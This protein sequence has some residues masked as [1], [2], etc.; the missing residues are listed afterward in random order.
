ARVTGADT[1]TDTDAR[2]VGAP[3]ADRVSAL[4]E[5]AR[6]LQE[7]GVAVEDIALR[8]PTLDEVFLHLTGNR[9]ADKT[10]T[11]VPA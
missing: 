6:A 9:T 11:E 8:R 4:T 5:T 10:E 1:E 7:A 3:V 2:R